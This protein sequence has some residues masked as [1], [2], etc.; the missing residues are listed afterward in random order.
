MSEGARKCPI[1]AAQVPAGAA[2]CPMCATP[3]S[4]EG[5]LTS[6]PAREEAPPTVAGDASSAQS[7]DDR[8]LAEHLSRS[9]VSGST[10]RSR[11]HQPSA[12]LMARMQRL[13]TWQANAK[14]LRVLVPTLPGWAEGVAATPAEEERWEEGVRGLERTAYKEI[15]SALDLWQ[16]E[17]GSRLNRLEAYGLPSPTERRSLEEIQRALKAGDLDRALD[18]YQKVANVVV[19]K[20]RNL[21]DAIESVEVVK[22]LSSD[23]EVLGIE[24]PWHD[25]GI[26]PRLESELRAGKVAE[27]HQEASELR[28]KALD[29]VSSTLPSRVN[30]AAERVAQEKGQGQDVGPEAALLAKAARA[31]RQGRSEEALREMVRFHNRKTL[32][33]FA[34]VEES[35][36][37]GG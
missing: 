7:E 30:E 29:L 10:V 14:G 27:A 33:P 21:D 13:Q 35:L 2:S 18:L 1:C 34:M 11:S 8:L 16:R 25:P 20:E 4:P 36:K 17:S 24:A 5:T 31:L 22:V 12:A 9:K 32:D 19:M 23:M 37:G 28:K 15:S 3:L 6:A 26:A